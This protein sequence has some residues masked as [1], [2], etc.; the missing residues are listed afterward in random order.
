M[1]RSMVSLSDF[2]YIY[3]AFDHPDRLTNSFIKES[4]TRQ[5]TGLQEEM[6]PGKG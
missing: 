2:A 6:P 5:T 1:K 4:S 3:P